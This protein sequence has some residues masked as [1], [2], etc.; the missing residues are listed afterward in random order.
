MKR[1][2]M[3]CTALGLALAAAL[4]MQAQA[5]RSCEQAKP[6]PAV[7]VKGMELAERTS[8]ALDASGARVVFLARAGQDLGKYGLRYSH[9]GIDR[10]SV[11]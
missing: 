4:P 9:L 11:V 5:G 10:K 3:A 6:T 1:A 2:L 8:Q 7:I